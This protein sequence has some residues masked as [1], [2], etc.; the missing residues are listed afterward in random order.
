[1]TLAHSRSSLACER[2]AREVSHLVLQGLLLQ[3]GGEG[4]KVLLQLFPLSLG[5]VALVE[6]DALLGHVLEALAVKLGQRLDAVLIDGLCQ[7]H[8]LVALLQQP[9]HEGGRLGLQTQG[10]SG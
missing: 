9:L 4:L 8:H 2:T 1:M 10:S 5:L 6:L 7:V 3:P